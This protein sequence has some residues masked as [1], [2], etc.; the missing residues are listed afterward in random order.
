[1]YNCT[2]KTEIRTTRLSV[3]CH[4]HTESEDSSGSDDVTK[5]GTQKI[6][7]SIPSLPGEEWLVAAQTMFLLQFTLHGSTSAPET[8]PS[9]PQTASENGIIM[10]SSSNK[11]FLSPS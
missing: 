8:W 10:Y 7:S 3:E 6:G 5:E 1:L 11:A 4:K 2:K 9:L